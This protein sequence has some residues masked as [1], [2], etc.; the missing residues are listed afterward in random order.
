MLFRYFAREILASEP[1]RAAGAARAL[2]VLRPDP[3]ARRP[4]QGQLPPRRDA[5][6]RGA[7]AAVARLRAAAGRGAHRHALRARAHVGAI[8]DHGDARLG[9]VAAP[10]RAARGAAP[11]WSS[12]SPRASSGELVPPYTEEAAKGLRL[13][14]TRSIVAREFRSGFWVK[15]DRS[16]VNIQDV[17]RATPSSSTCASTSSTPLPARLDQPRREGHLRGRRTRGACANVELTRFE[18]E[19]ARAGAARQVEL[20]LGAHARHPLGAEDR[21]RSACR[22]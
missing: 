11:A 14:A 12:R 10:A 3:R 17:T 13:K 21:A 6:L 15:D 8:R 2:R 5:R 22:R 20:E 16:F 9:P 19:R 1:A 18:G 7:V 4:G